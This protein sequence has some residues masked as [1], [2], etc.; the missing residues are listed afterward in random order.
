MGIGAEGGVLPTLMSASNLGYFTV[1]VA[2]C[3]ALPGPG[4]MDDAM[5]YIADGAIVGT[6]AELLELWR[7]A[8]AKPAE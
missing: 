7:G 1:A 4:R 6:H 8:A 3:L 5:R 2:D